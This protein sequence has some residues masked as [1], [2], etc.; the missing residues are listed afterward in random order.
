MQQSPELLIGC[1]TVGAVSTNWAL[2]LYQMEKPLTVN[3]R[4]WQGLPFDVARNRLVRDAQEAG[5]RYLLFLDTDVLPPVN[6]L[7]Q[8]L[9]RK[10]PIISGLVWAKRGYP[11]IWRRAGDS[12]SPVTGIS[13]G[14][15]AIVE[16]DAVPMG[17]C[18]IDMRVFD[19][20]P[21]PW[22][23]WRI[24]DPVD[25]KAGDVSEDFAFCAKAIEAGFRIYVDTGVRCRH[26]TLVPVSP[27]DDIKQPD[28]AI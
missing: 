21:Y 13:E 4:A 25:K 28:G 23:E 11:G 19:V 27:F 3:I 18:L 17:C 14:H 26:E 5:A 8:L 10:L 24:A 12:Y 16:A 9:W 20:V 6:A 2:Q 1:P 22:F 7:R 15:N